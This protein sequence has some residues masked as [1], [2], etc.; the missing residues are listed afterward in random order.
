MIDRYELLIDWNNN[1]V[2][3]DGETIGYDK[4]MD[5][6]EYEGGY[7]YSNNP[8]GKLVAGKLRAKVYDPERQY[9]PLNADSPIYG[10]VLPNRRMRLD[11]VKPDGTR[12]YLWT[13]L[14]DW[15]EPSESQDTVP[16]AV[17]TGYGTMVKANYEIDLPVYTDIFLNNAIRRTLNILGI[18]TDIPEIIY[19]GS[20][21]TSAR[22]SLGSDAFSG[23]SIVGSDAYVLN[24]NH[25]R[26]E[27]WSLTTKAEDTGARV[28]LGSDEFGGL[29]IVGS[30]AYVLN[31]SDNRIE[32]WRLSGG[33]DTGARVSLS[34]DE[35]GGLHIVGSDA[36]VL[37][38]N[39][40]RIEK[41][42][43]TT[44]AEDTSARVSLGSD[45]FSGLS[46]VGSDAYVLNDNHNRIE[47]WSLTTKA[48]D[49]GARVSLSS[50]AFSGLSIVGSDA[51]V[52]NDGDNRIEKWS[53]AA[54]RHFALHRRTWH[55]RKPVRTHTR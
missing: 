51:Y 29:H 40:N 5:R 23:L 55:G 53:A 33:E 22:V 38:D 45:A 4:L 10:R 13:G 47:K 41:W 8:H 37:N 9:Q 11:A 2:F 3:G 46:I 34:S 39:D 24:D 21:D 31:D 25:N 12:I 43:L 17:I 20:E 35:F 50:D 6:I 44:K 1:G 26:I 18:E 54:A 30:D 52:L 15:V 48:E 27:K 19:T 49:T 42:S 16:T 14:L 32:K 7:N 28:S 36:Y